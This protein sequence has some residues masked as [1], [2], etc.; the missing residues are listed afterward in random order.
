[1]SGRHPMI[2]GAWGRGVRPVV[3]SDE[4]DIK[5]GHHFLFRG[6]RLEYLSVKSGATWS[7]HYKIAIEDCFLRWN[8]NNIFG[9]QVRHCYAF[10]AWRES[11]T[12]GTTMKDGK[13]VWADHN[14]RIQTTHGKDTHGVLI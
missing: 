12:E 13:T 6:L 10:D 14:N 7:P 11:P 1:M 3:T 4:V 9:A 8:L 2:W 5:N